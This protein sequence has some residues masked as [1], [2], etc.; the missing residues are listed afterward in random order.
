MDVLR[1]I[2]HDHVRGAEVE[3]ATYQILSLEVR[4]QHINELLFSFLGVNK[5]LVARNHL[6]TLGEL[7]STILLAH[8]I[9]K[10]I[11]VAIIQVDH[12]FVI[13]CR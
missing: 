8:V 10:L 7:L 11:E 4:P 5:I 6:E 2:L 12:L 13:I 9:S 1:V 3:E